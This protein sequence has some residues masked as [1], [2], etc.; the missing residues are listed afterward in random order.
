MQ[1]FCFIVFYNGDREISDEHE[2]HLSD[3]FEGGKVEGFEWTAKIINI[4]G[5][6]SLA[7]HRN[8]MTA[9]ADRKVLRMANVL[10][11]AADLAKEVT[12]QEE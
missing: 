3:A 11:L 4:K 5:T 7:L 12:L 10:E 8:Y 6:H 1:V 9:T 2:Q